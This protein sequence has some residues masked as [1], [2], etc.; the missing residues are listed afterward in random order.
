MQAN[1]YI[2]K[3]SF[4]FTCLCFLG[5]L[6]MYATGLS[7]VRVYINPGHGSFGAN[8]RPMATIPYPNLPTTGMPDTCGFYES[9]TNLWKAQALGKKL[10]EAGAKVTYSRTKSGPWPYVLKNGDYPDY[11]STKYN[12]LPDIEKYNRSLSEISEEVEASNYD[13]FISIH[14]NA[15]GTDATLTNYP[16]IL[17]RGTDDGTD[18]NGDS[19]TRAEKLWPYLYAAMASGI[20]PANSYSLTNTNVR[21]DIDF[22]HSSSVSTRGSTGKQYRG[23]L[24]VLKHGCPGFLSEGYFHT[25]QPARHRALNKDY[26]AQEGIRYFRGINAYYEG[27]GEKTG[28]IMGTVKDMFNPLEHRLYTYRGATNDQYAPLNGAIV[29]LYKSGKQIATY[30]TDNFCNGLFIFENLEPGDDY[31]LDATCEGYHNLSD[32]YK[33]PISVVAN[34]TTYPLIFLKK[35]AI[36]EINVDSV[37]VLNV[38]D[39]TF[40][41]EML[42]L[43]KKHTI[44][45]YFVKDKKVYVQDAANAVLYCFDALT[46][47]YLGTEASVKDVFAI[48]TDEAGNVIFFRWR[49][50]E[51]GVQPTLFDLYNHAITKE[52]DLQHTG[53][54]A[55][56]PTVS[57]NLANGTGYVYALG[58]DATYL[59]ML[60]YDNGTFTSRDSL[61]LGDY[62]FGSNFVSPIDENHVMV[63]QREGSLFVLD[64]NTLEKTVVSTKHSV[65]SHHGGLYFEYGQGKF[66]VQGDQGENTCK[67]AF[68]IYDMTEERVT[69]TY[70]QEH[71]LGNTNNLGSSAVIFEKMIYDNA[72]YLY[73]YVPGVCLACYKV[74]YPGVTITGV[75]NTTK[76]EIWPQQ[77]YS[78][79]GQYLMTAGSRED[80]N[81]LPNGCYM[82]SGKEKIIIN[83]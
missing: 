2:M 39:K 40:P 79:S 44:G 41:E 14:S 38:S 66:F 80:M 69:E 24:G 83:K 51:E 33:K 16:V 67:G 81:V 43:K 62:S 10:V 3:K 21:G 78:P 68:K 30:T 57:G 29:T 1:C 36:Q 5:C 54:A 49:N 74:S 25:Y 56:Y 73:E 20:D 34:E 17:Y 53:G 55:K 35:N 47:A 31:T 50:E 65:T 61:P 59:T 32:K 7:G 27:E 13:Y 28:Y 45:G 22:Y 58:N 42:S 60:R 76:T 71:D 18:Q 26:C 8:D 11:S 23:Y 82:T 37:W 19:K 52:W 12:A 72:I 4:I 77:I 9:N 63:M 75:E 48:D 64:L 46:G 15:T 70:Y 6:S